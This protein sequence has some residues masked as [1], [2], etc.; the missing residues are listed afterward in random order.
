MKVIRKCYYENDTKEN[1]LLKQRASDRIL[2]FTYEKDT[3][4]FSSEDKQAAL[5]Y[6]FY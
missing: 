2:L 4:I 5:I 6:V 3:S 1:D